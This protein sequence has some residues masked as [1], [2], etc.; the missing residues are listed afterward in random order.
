MTAAQAQ[1]REGKPAT[2]GCQS[3]IHLC[4]NTP[5]AVYIEI[6]GPGLPAPTDKVTELL[7]EASTGGVGL[8]FC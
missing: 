4:N 3:G 6:L 5:A 1:Q 2:D 7:S 8:L